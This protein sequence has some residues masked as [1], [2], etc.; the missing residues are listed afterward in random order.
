MLGPEK[1]YRGHY[2]DPAKPAGIAIDNSEETIQLA[3][4]RLQDS[5]V[6][7]IEHGR[8]PLVEE[9][10]CIVVQS[11][12]AKGNLDIKNDPFSI[13]V[14]QIVNK[15]IGPPLC[16]IGSEPNNPLRSLPPVTGAHHSLP[17][18]RLDCP[19]NVPPH[20]GR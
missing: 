14:P 3:F 1:Q 8:I 15:S 20:D 4:K 19:V 10:L 9:H 17:P 16:T 13:T 5:M 7:A 18:S 12:L 2:A 11:H 6:Q